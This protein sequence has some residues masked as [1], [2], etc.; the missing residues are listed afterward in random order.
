VAGAAEQHHDGRQHRHANQQHRAASG[1]RVRQQSSVNGSQ[2]SH[3]A[4]NEF[5]QARLALF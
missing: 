3:V 2:P 4:L 5:L 1:Q